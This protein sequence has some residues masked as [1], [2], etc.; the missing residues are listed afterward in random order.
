MGLLLD[1]DRYNRHHVRLSLFFLPQWY[2]PDFDVC[3]L[4]MVHDII[5]VL[6]SHARD[7][8]RGGGYTPTTGAF[9]SL[10]EHS[11]RRE[12]QSKLGTEHSRDSSRCRE[13]AN[14]TITRPDTASYPDLRT[15][16]SCVMFVVTMRP[17]KRGLL[18]PIRVHDRI[19]FHVV[20]RK[21]RRSSTRVTSIL[22]QKARVSL[23]HPYLN[24]MEDGGMHRD[25]GT[26]AGHIE[27]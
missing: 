14:S 3:S 5:I 20:R 25:P 10:A 19:E 11:A 27:A 21:T 12:L 2:R 17:K 22:L 24:N 26:T 23:R 6:S 1:F 15:G 16:V 18:V 9:F 7:I 8:P 4:C 13:E